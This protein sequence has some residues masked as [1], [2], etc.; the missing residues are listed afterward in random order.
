[1]EKERLGINGDGTLGV[2]RGEPLDEGEAFGIDGE[3]A[4]GMSLGKLGGDI[5]EQIFYNRKAHRTLAAGH[6][7]RD[8][9]LSRKF[10][11]ASSSVSLAVS[12]AVTDFLA[13]FAFE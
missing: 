3:V 6:P 4:L 1:M 12:I 13:T 7:F 9:L 8:F 2:N 10:S 11:Y 5:Y